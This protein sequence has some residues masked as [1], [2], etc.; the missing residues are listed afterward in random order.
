MYYLGRPALL[1]NPAL[2]AEQRLAQGRRGDRAEAAQVVDHRA[3]AEVDGVDH[4]MPAA[5]KIVSRLGHGASV[6][7]DPSRRARARSSREHADGNRGSCSH[8][9][10][11]HTG[12]AQLALAQL[13]PPAEHKQIDQ[14]DSRRSCRSALLPHS[15]RALDVRGDHDQQPHRPLGDADHGEM[16]QA[17][18][19]RDIGLAPVPSRGSS[20]LDDVGI[21]ENRRA[22]VLSR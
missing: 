10:L 16:R 22:P 4:R 15:H 3:A 20:R 5:P 12:H 11:R 14:A 6:A 7:A 17:D 1:T 9:D 21:T 19:Q 13:D 8:H 2:P 18:Q